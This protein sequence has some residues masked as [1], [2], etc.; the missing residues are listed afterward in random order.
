[1]IGT[2]VTLEVSEIPASSLLAAVVYGRQKYDPGL[3]LSSLGMP[4][5]FQYCGMEAVALL[6]PSGASTATHLFAVPND[7]GLVGQNI[8]AQGAAF[9]PAGAHNT[10]GALSSNGLELTIGN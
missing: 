10:L 3:P 7:P 6:F 8:R 9:D 4:E 2:T 5:C 1:M